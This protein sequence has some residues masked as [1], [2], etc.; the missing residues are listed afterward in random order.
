MS[1]L[2]YLAR[3]GQVFGPYSE[4]ELEQI[5]HS[6]G[7]SQYTWMWPDGAK[8]WMPIDPPPPPIGHTAKPKAAS[9]VDWEAIGFNNEAAINGF[10][11]N[12][13]DLG[14]ELTTMD[15]GVEP[16]F[17]ENTPVT[18]NV[19]HTKK[20]RSM[21]VQARMTR[22]RRDSGCWVYHFQWEKHPDL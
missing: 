1:R 8:E 12:T 18:L 22:A 11:R 3:N 17:G 19:L 21:N 2:T 13:S 16:V 5:R 15:R 20:G 14:C 6:N 4:M 9:S 10:L 7:L